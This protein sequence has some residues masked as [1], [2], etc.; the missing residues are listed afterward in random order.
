VDSDEDHLYPSGRK[1]HL[2]RCNNEI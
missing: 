1:R 2:R